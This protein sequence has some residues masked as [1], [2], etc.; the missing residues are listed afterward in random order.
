MKTLLVAFFVVPIVAFAA[1]LEKPTL[2]LSADAKL[3]ASVP[4]IAGK[5]C[6]S[7]T[8]IVSLVETGRPDTFW[9]A[10]RAAVPVEH[11]QPNTCT[12]LIGPDQLAG[13]LRHGQDLTAWVQIGRH[14]SNSLPLTAECSDAG[15]H[16]IE[17]LPISLFRDKPSIGEDIKIMK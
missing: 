13:Q 1:P 7:R 5:D 17:R 14:K 16:L 11:Q 4:R 15:C 3:S 2:S 12:A 9:S 10:Y 6:P 8:A